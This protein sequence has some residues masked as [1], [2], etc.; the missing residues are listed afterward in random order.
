MPQTD[1]LARVAPCPRPIPS[2][3]PHYS[4]HALCNAYWTEPARVIYDHEL[5]LFNQGKFTVEIEGIR[6]ES[7][8]NTFL[9]VPPGKTHTTWETAGRHGHRYWIHFDW[10]WHGSFAETPM[11]AF[12]PAR[13][14]SKYLRPAPDYVPNEI[15]HGKIPAPSRAWEL[16]ERIITLQQQRNTHD[17]LVCRALLLELLVELLDNPAS[18]IAPRAGEL[19]LAQSVRRILDEAIERKSNQRI[20][21][22]LESLGY[23]YA[24]L[25]RIFR[26]HYGLAP[27]RYVHAVHMSRAKQLLRNT[28]WKI[29]H[30]AYHLGYNSPLYFTRLFRQMVGQT[31]TQ[32]ARELPMS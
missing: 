31:P 5:V 8:A 1:W 7:G 4:G 18:H 15:L 30:I 13:C 23:S 9:I 27:L 24:H 17:L 21:E 22:L 29:A 19:A 20:E 12:A 2:A 6:Y 10:C 14:Q 28:D 32:Y 25:C 11:A 16:S 26:R 3:G